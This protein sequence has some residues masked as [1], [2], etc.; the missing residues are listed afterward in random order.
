MT[1]STR[2]P[3]KTNTYCIV[4]CV[5]AKTEG[6]TT[7]LLN[8]SGLNVAQSVIILS[9]RNFS[10]SPSFPSSKGFILSSSKNNVH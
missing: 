8:A 4:V 10:T 2:R 6:T 9:N 3:T 5:E 1:G 7:E